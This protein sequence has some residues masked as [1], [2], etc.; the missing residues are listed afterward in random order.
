VNIVNGTSQYQDQDFRVSGT[1]LFWYFGAL[2]NK[3]TAGDR[4][5]LIYTYNP[6]VGAKVEFTYHILNNVLASVIV[7][8]WSRIMDDKYVFAGLCHDVEA[9]S[10]GTTLTEY[11]PGLDDDSDGI[12]LSFFNT[13]TLEVEKHKFTGPVFETYEALED[14]IGAPEN[15]YNSLVRIKKFNGNSPL[16]YSATYS[17]I[18]DKLV[19]FRKKTF[20]ELMPDKTFRS[21]KI[22]EMLPV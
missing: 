20:R 10:I 19:R 2:R 21:S 17:F 5:R 3:L 16:N 22:V 8:D 18:N 9:I 12:T 4:L 11:L 6:Y 13:D 14:E 15:Y 7:R 1:R